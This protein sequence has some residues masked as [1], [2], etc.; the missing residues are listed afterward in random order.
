MDNYTPDILKQRFT[1][2]KEY[3]MSL[4]TIIDLGVKARRPNFP[5]D[6]SEN[7]IKFIIQNKLDDKSSSWNCDG[8]LISEKEGIQECKCFTSAGPS[9]FSPKSKWDVIYFLD[10]TNWQDDKFILYRVALKATSDEWKNIK[11]NKTTTF[12]SQCKQGRRPRINWK[13]L[14]PQIEDFCSVVYEGTF[15]GIF[16]PPAKE[17]SAD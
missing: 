12:N 1:T 16:T 7:I 8:D 15:E 2:F 11:V 9:S 13:Y 14:K 10:A 5:E 6:M 17:E 3:T 4:Q